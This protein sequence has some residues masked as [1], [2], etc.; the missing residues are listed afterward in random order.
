LI[1]LH[2]LGT[3]LQSAEAWQGLGKGDQLDEMVA[4]RNPDQISDDGE[5]LALV[6]GCLGLFNHEQSIVCKTPL[7]C[8]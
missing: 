1:S 4:G 8:N 6:S 3:H 7:L 5:L 2:G